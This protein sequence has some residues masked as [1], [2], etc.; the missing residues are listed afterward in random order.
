MAMRGEV[1]DDISRIDNADDRAEAD[2]RLQDMV[3]RYHKIVL[4]LAN[5][6]EENN[7]EALTVFALPARRPSRVSRHLQ[8]RGCF[9]QPFSKS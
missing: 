5:W 3:G 9:I 2:Q 4:A 6:L 8:K 1:A 7:S